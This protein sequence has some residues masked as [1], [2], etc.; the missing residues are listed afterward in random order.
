LLLP[1]NTTSVQALEQSVTADESGDSTKA[2]TRMIELVNGT[3][4]AVGKT[5]PLI[6][7]LGS[8]TRIKDKCEDT[9]KICE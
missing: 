3:G 2:R 8:L 9:L 1:A 5:V 6:G 7:P 4:M